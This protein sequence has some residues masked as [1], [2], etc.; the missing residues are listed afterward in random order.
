M[1]A[2]LVA[3]GQWLVC[4]LKVSELTDRPFSGD[5]KNEVKVLVEALQSLTETAMGNQLHFESF[6]YLHKMQYVE[7]SRSTVPR[8]IDPPP[9]AAQFNWLA[10]LLSLRRQGSCNTPYNK[11]LWALQLNV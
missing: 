2:R 9:T 1:K 10:T 3:R 11:L 5:L 6:L 4:S 7:I 8:G